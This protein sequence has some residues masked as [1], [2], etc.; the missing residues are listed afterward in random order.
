MLPESVPALLSLERQRHVQELEEAHRSYEHAVAEHKATRSAA[1]RIQGEL[2]HARNELEDARQEGGE[3]VAKHTSV[4]DLVL[5]LKAVN[6]QLQRRV[7][8]E[9]E[10]AEEKERVLSQVRGYLEE[11]GMVG[12][13]R[14]T[15]DL[16]GALTTRVK[17]AE[18]E[19]SRVLQEL[20]GAEI[21]LSQIG[22]VLWIAPP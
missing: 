14:S 6:A 19:L 4:S 10:A 17:E 13:G 8:E 2:D 3:M 21:E 12:H 16:T 11:V 5:E 22:E 1:E 9:Q 15:A 7:H 18:H 20:R